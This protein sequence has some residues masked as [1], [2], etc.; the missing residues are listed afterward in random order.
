MTN[1]QKG[2]KSVTAHMIYNLATALNEPTSKIGES[3]LPSLTVP[4]KELERCKVHSTS[5]FVRSI[6]R[7]A[8]KLPSA[9]APIDNAIFT[10]KKINISLRTCARIQKVSAE[11]LRRQAKNGAPQK[12]SKTCDQG[13][14][15]P[16]VTDFWFHWW[17][18]M[19]CLY[20]F[21]SQL[22]SIIY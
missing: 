14:H 3:T 17:P 7:A 21:R 12:E 8:K 15:R 5:C 11:T 16:Y 19:F 9:M 13:I 20:K 1:N 6:Y 2:N 22:C 4:Q 18:H 10:L